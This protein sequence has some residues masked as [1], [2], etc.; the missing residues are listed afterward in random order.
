MPL[1]PLRWTHGW[2]LC[3][4]LCW[5]LAC[6]RAAPHEPPP[7]AAPGPQAVDL[8]ADRT[9]WQ[10]SGW[11]FEAVDGG[12]SVLRVK[13]CCVGGGA[14]NRPL[15]AGPGSHVVRIGYDNTECR[16]IASVEVALH[17]ETGD[18][19]PWKRWHSL[20]DVRLDDAAGTKEL[21][22]TL[23][24]PPP[25]GTRLMLRLYG[26]GGLRCCGETHVASVVLER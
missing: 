3:W 21:A 15:P 8:L 5:S 9:T 14:F 24:A 22:F 12:A 1:A 13:A 10:G 16:Q 11:R 18:A 2:A 6:Q 20:A 19:A 17:E 23:D 7:P 4:A 25:P 26:S